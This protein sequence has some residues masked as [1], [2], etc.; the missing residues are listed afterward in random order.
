MLFL[1]SLFHPKYAK[2]LCS[3]LVLVQF[4]AEAAQWSE[5]DLELQRQQQQLQDLRQKFEPEQHVLSGLNTATR[6][7]RLPATESPCFLIKKI[8][9]QGEFFTFGSLQ[10]QLAGPD[11]DDAPEG[12]CLGLQSIQ[13]LAERIQNALIADGYIT[14]RVTVNSQDLTQALLTLNVLPGRIAKIRYRGESTTGPYLSVLLPTTEGNVLNLRHIEQALENF[15]RAPSA[16]VDIQIE[17]SHEEGLSDLVFDY[18]QA[19]PYRFSLS[20]DDSGS[21]ETGK[22]QGNLTGF[23]DNLLN[24]SDTLYFSYLHNL[25][26]I[27]SAQNGTEGYIF[28]YSLP[29]GFWQLGLT[30]SSNQYHQTVAGAYQNYLYSGDS[31]QQEIQISY[32]LHR[33]ASS[34]TN[35]DLSVFSRSSHNYIDDTEVAVQRRLTSGWELSLN[36]RHQFSQAAISAGLSYKRG[37]GAFNALPAPEE[38]FDEGTSRMSLL[39]ATLA[40]DGA[41]NAGAQHFAYSSALRGQHAFTLLTPQDRFC[42]GSRH[43]VRGFDGSQSLC[44]DRGLTWRNEIRASLLDGQIQPYLG[45]DGGMVSGPRSEFLAGRHLAGGVLGIRGAAGPVQYDLFAGG[46]LYQPPKKISSYTYGFS[47]S[48]SF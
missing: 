8:Q 5:T 33:N 30:A 2:L 17:P 32:V 28:H 46:P 18:Q 9:L 6:G 31:A 26:G 47:L 23:V 15:R 1:S 40:V 45:L 4:N 36:H 11:G 44:A 39:N 27:G 13:L 34:K 29:F 12:R 16:D 38:L 42:I 43:S 41:F 48:L 22:Y 35:L 10:S 25:D 24:V 3:F 7:K 20:V 19:K 14:T 37:T 21:S